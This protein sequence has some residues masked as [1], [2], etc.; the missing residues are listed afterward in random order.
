MS[1]TTKTEYCVTLTALTHGNRTRYVTSMRGSSIDLAISPQE[2]ARKH[3]HE[4]DI[5]FT[6]SVCPWFESPTSSY[7]SRVVRRNMRGTGFEPADP[8]G[9]AS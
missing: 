3:M 4:T 5:N 1:G 9:I 7:D 8:Y 2:T 6:H